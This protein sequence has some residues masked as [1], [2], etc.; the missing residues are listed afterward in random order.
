[1]ATNG[2]VVEMLEESLDELLEGAKYCIEYSK[3][4][5][6]WDKKRTGGCLGYPGGILLFSIIDSIRSY[7]RGNKDFKILVD[8]KPTTIDKSGWE[9]FKILNSKYFNLGLSQVDLKMLYN[10]YRSSLVHNGVLGN[11]VFMYPSS[12]GTKFNNLAISK[13]GDGEGPITPIVFVKE[14]HIACKEAVELFKLD[15][16]AIVPYSKQVQDMNLKK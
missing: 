16:N 8:R 14:L 3:F 1:M 4:G 15:M 6:P 11:G 10:Q 13:L 5:P 7:F 9:H 2:S 12:E